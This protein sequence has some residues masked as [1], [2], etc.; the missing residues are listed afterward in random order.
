MR[1]AVRALS[2]VAVLAVLVAGC[3]TLKGK[4]MGQSVDDASLTT[5]VK[6]KLAAEKVD[7]L[8]KISVNTNRGTV[9]LTGNVENE[10]V[11]ERATQIAR[12]VRGVEEVVNHLKIQATQ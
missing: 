11:K 10:A 4:T 9:Y 3:T 8:T 6:A 7:T 12:S 5:A 1:Y 2:L